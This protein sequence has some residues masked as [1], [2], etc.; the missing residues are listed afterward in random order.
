MG[1]RGLILAT[2]FSTSV[3]AEPNFFDFEGLVDTIRRN[4]I[5]TIED[6]LGHLPDHM[7]RDPVLMG[8]SLSV[9]PAT[10]LNPR[11]L[12]SNRDSSLIITFNGDP[13]LVDD[14]DPNTGERQPH[15]NPYY[16]LEVM[17]FRKDRRS[18]EFREIRFSPTGM[19]P[20][21]SEKTQP[22]A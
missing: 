4:D 15:L 3:L 22:S 17:Q 5:R 2:F 8:K 16:K 9:Q 11:V 18:F 21:I 10:S 12:L 6:L 19:P 7:L 1:I 20:I 13:S 14:R